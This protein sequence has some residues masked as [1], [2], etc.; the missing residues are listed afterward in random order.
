MLPLVAKNYILLFMKTY[1]Q[2]EYY[3]DDPELPKLFM[4]SWVRP[5]LT[6]KGC[7]LITH[8]IAEHSDCYDH[9]AKALADHQWLVFG[10]D[11]QGHGRS[12][13]KRGYVREFDHFSRDLKTIIKKIKEDET[14]PTSE[15]HLIGHSMGG[16]ITLQ[17]LLSD[18]PPRIK[19]AILSSPATGIAMEVPKIK[20]V[21]SRLLNQFWPTLT[22]NTEMQYHLLSRDPEKTASYS[23]DPLRHSKI[24]APLYEGMLSTMDWVSENI[25]KLST[26]VFFQ[27]AGKDGIVNTQ[28][29]LDLFKKIPGKKKLKLY[30][31][32]FHEIYNDLNKQEGI[33]DLIDYLGQ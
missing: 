14:L 16:L 2:R 31:E 24:S 20:E 22:I 23:K 13:G 12:P 6:P 27:I 21:A 10:W 15:F 1:E 17:T 28:A 32:S 8:G 30:E 7:V 19:S 11:L 29:S 9:V 33:D 3:F 18:H 4:Q 5:D 26:P 25:S